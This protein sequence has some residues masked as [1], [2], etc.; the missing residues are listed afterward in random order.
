MIMQ[1][2]ITVAPEFPADLEWINVAKPLK[3]ADLRGKIVLLDFWTACSVNCMHIAADLASLEQKYPR[4]LVVIGVH[5]AK[6]Y[7]E[8]DT[9]NLRQSVLRLGIEHPVVNDSRMAVWREYGANAWP[10]LVL[11]DPEGRVAGQ[12]SG[13]GV[14]KPIDEAVTGLIKTYHRHGQLDRRPLRLR[15]SPR[16]T[17]KS[18]LEFPGKVL[19]DEATGQLFIADTGHNRILVAD[20]AGGAVRTVIG[21]GRAGFRD[22]HFDD[23]EF[24][25]PMGMAVAGSRLYI[26]D[27]GNH[28]IRAADLRTGSV[29][30]LAGTGGQARRFDISGPG[31]TTPLN[32]PWDLVLAG[33]GLYIAMAGNHQIWRLDLATGY[34]APWAGSG[35]EGRHDEIGRA[36]V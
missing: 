11:I 20:L 9:E 31:R 24:N 27:S 12:W 17:A 4:E 14:I 32:S 30:T 26:A 29:V 13:E 23:A 8:R 7:A 33:T 1:G 5:S 3:L 15:P 34:V 36:H 25:R 35:R 28:A 18:I 10:T 16:A 21:G 19:A 6:F 22:G 2:T